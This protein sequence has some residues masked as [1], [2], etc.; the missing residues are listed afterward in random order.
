[1]AFMLFAIPTEGD[2]DPDAQCHVVAPHKPAFKHDAK[3]TKKFE[4]AKT[5]D[6]LHDLWN[7]IDVGLRKE[8]ADF[9]DVA[10]QRIGGASA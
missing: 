8:Y 4:E 7:S 1:M 10:K 3:I 6:E 9:K 5:L 2:N